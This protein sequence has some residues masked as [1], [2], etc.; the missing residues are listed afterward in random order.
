MK[1]IYDPEKRAVY[2]ETG[3]VIQDVA[4]IDIEIT[5]QGTTASISMHR[6]DIRV[7]GMPSKADVDAIIKSV[8]EIHDDLAGR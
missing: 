3:E 5:P 6:L 4:G 2:T 1:L 7:L 8:E